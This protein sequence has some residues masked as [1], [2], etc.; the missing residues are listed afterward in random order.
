MTAEK[1]VVLINLRENI[2][3]AAGEMNINIDCVVS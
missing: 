1:Q 3:K 2:D